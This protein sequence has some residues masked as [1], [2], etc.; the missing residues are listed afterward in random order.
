MEIKVTTERG[1]QYT[2][3]VA[4]GTHMD[5]AVDNLKHGRE[6]VFAGWLEVANSSGDRQWIRHDT[7]IEILAELTD[8][9][10]DDQPS[11]DLL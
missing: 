5:D 3:L 10:K 11:G 1:E 8:D 4:F 7:V 2:A 6:P 9:E